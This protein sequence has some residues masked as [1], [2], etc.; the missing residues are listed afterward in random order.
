MCARHHL[1]LLTSISFSVSL[2]I[3]SLSLLTPAS[4]LISLISLLITLYLFDG[5][6]WKSG[7]WWH[8]AFDLIQKEPTTAKQVM[9]ETLQ[10]DVVVNFRRER[11]AT[12]WYWWHVTNDLMAIV[13]S[14]GNMPDDANGGG[15]LVNSTK[16]SMSWWPTFHYWLSA[17]A[18]NQCFLYEWLA[19][20]K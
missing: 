19:C 18:Y 4:S 16:V 1:S 10:C 11:P 20:G 15:C 13:N 12:M 6:Y 8:L 17:V 7:K 5:Y 9:E 2:S 3:S 14:V